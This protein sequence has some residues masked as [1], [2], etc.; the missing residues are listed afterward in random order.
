MSIIPIRTISQ[1]IITALNATSLATACELITAYHGEIEDLLDS[2][3]SQ[4]IPLP[5]I[6][7]CY[8]GSEFPEPG[9][10][11]FDD[12]QTFRIILLAKNLFPVEVENIPADQ[13]EAIGNI[14]SM[15]ETIKTTLINNNLSLNIEP[16]RPLSVRAVSVPNVGGY[17]LEMRTI[18]SR[19]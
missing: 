1:A 12:E 15:L 14:Y 10:R 6:L 2:L 16:L 8:L 13:D 7:V 17:S 9:N 18:F 19:Y 3:A 11:S 5:A 4:P